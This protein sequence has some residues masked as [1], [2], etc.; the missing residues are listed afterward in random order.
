M[1]GPGVA[2]IGRKK[3]PPNFSKSMDS[4]FR[5]SVGVCMGFKR[6]STKKGCLSGSPGGLPVLILDCPTSS[7][8][9]VTSHTTMLPVRGV[10]PCTHSVTQGKSA[11]SSIDPSLLTLKGARR[12]PRRSRPS[13]AT[14]AKQRVTILGRTINVI[15]STFLWM[16]YTAAVSAQALQL[17]GSA[18]RLSGNERE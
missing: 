10:R 3:E 8:R 2:H 13:S 9:R 1:S 4:S 14:E 6:S 16:H 7:T 15:L 17:R 18:P 5:T 11:R 12:L